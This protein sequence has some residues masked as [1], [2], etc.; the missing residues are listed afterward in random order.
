M[1]GL[2]LVCVVRTAAWS[3][4]SRFS[5]QE[6]DS[7]LKSFVY[8]DGM[9]DYRGLKSRP[10]ELETF[11]DSVGKLDA[12]DFAGWTDKEKI[13]FWINAYNALTLKVILDHYPI[14]PSL[15]GRIRFPSNSI[16]QISGVWD[17]IRFKVMG[18]EM[19]LDEIEHQRLRK[20]FNEPRVHMALVCASRGC[21]VLRD[22]PYS[23]DRLDAQLDHQA[24]RFLKDPNKFRIDRRR[25]VVQLSSIFQWFAKDF[26]KTYDTSDKFHGFSPVERP[27]LNFVAGYLDRKDRQFLET[28]GY[29][30]EYLPYDWSLNER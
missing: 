27:V 19:T 3:E 14:R 8:K 18:G 25:E 9:V 22:E 23:A 13:A 30:I 7:V 15:L 24:T 1:V 6:Y 16:R 10:V 11:V 28:E 12:K 5:Y 2:A 21:P 20:D 26:G 17:S 4:G 29:S